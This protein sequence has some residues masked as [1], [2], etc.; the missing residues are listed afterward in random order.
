[1]TDEDKI[2]LAIGYLDNLKELMG[3]QKFIKDLLEI[4]KGK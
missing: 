4:L 2:N 1:M 3:E